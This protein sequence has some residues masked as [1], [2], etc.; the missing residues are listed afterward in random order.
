[1]NG[2]DAP[3]VVV[4]VG[5]SLLDWP[6]LPARLRQY[7]DRRSANRLI[8]VVGGGAVADLIRAFD[9]RHRI[10]DDR[11]HV[12]AL[13]ALDLSAYL[14]EDIVPDCRVVDQLDQVE[15]VQRSGQVPIF[16]PRRWLLEVDGR[17]LDP[18]PASWEITSDAISARLAVRLGA[19]ELA[20]L[21]SAKA[22]AGTDRASAARLGLVDLAFPGVSEALPLVTYLNLRDSEETP[23]IL[24]GASDSPADRS[25]C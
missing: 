16:A 7:L 22:P 23:Q 21:K 11:A 3:L 18:L 17:S 2:P 8:L 13:R 9:D 20:L 19:S 10:G 14:L 15:A 12:L 4:K 5:G 24:P 25:S 6:D 1:M